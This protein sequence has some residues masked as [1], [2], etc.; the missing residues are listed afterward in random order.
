MQKLKILKGFRD[1]FPS[2][3]RLRRWMIGEL[4]KVFESF[5]FKP[6]ETPTLEYLS[7]LKGKYGDEAE[8]L[9][10]SF[11]DRGGREVGLRYDLTVPTSRFLVMNL[12]KRIKLPFKRYQIQ[13]VF[14]ADKPQRGRLREFTQ[15]DIDTF[16]VS[17]PLADVEIIQVMVEG[18]KALGINNFVIKLNSRAILEDVLTRSGV[19]EKTKRLMVLREIDKLEKIGKEKVESNLA[20]KGL[21]AKAIKAIFKN[22]SSIKMDNSL[23]DIVSFLKRL[24]IKN[25]EFT[26]FL[27]RGL[28]YYTGII[29]ETVL[30]DFPEVGSVMGGGRYD[31]LIKELGSMDVKAVG[32][33]FGFER[34]FEFLSKKVSL[35]SSYLD[36]VLVTVFD[37]D[38]M[39]KS[40]SLYVSLRRKGIPARIF[41]D[42]NKKL[43]NQLKYA[44]EEKIKW[45]VIVGPDEIKKGEIVLRDMENSVQKNISL[46]EAIEILRS[47]K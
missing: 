17:P 1:F 24:R 44:V 29:F 42:A 9:L 21:R 33:S 18:L 30:V 16:G 7:L 43:R 12:N 6:V 35:S 22:I 25:F 41:L 39:E 8:K 14:R 40:F 31:N 37:K 3:L 45:V 34:L 26:P 13:N 32:T 23:S 5:G 2:E 19:E 15:C 10:Y 11:R 47:F 28:D 36:S 20:E 38:L 27:V 4:I 46:D